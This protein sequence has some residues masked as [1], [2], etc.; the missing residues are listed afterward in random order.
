MDTIVWL[1]FQRLIGGRIWING[2][3]KLAVTKKKKFFKTA[4]ARKAAVAPK[5]AAASTPSTVKVNFRPAFKKSLEKADNLYENNM[6]NFSV[7]SEIK[8]GSCAQLSDTYS[9]REGLIGA[10]RTLLYDNDLSDKK[11]SIM[12]Y[13]FSGGK[14]NIGGQF[15]DISYNK[16]AADSAK[17]GLKL[18]NHFEKRNKWFRTKAYRVDHKY[19]KEYRMYVFQGSRWWMTSSYV[20]SLFLLL[21]RIARRTEIHKIAANASTATLTKS[22]MSLPKGDDSGYAVAAD[23]WAVFLNN[24]RKIFRGRKTFRDNFKATGDINAEG[25]LKLINNNARDEE[26]QKRFNACLKE[27]GLSVTK[28]LN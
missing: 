27:A 24:R 20:L 10:F 23:K 13:T 6:Y 12:V 19:N 22:I 26:V 21:L 25:I 28:R 8:N 1:W 14:T 5:K 9:C 15:G 18:L 3:D 2:G 4:T 16:W 11:I 17:A 7:C